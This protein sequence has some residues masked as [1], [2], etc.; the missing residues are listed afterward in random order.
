MA[1][2]LDN[3]PLRE[4][5]ADKGVPEVLLAACRALMDQPDVARVRHNLLDSCAAPVSIEP[6]SH[7]VLMMF[8]SSLAAQGIMRFLAALAASPTVRPASAAAPFTRLVVSALELYCNDEEIVEVRAS[9][10]EPVINEQPT[11]ESVP[12]GSCCRVGLL[13]AGR[14]SR[15]S[16]SQHPRR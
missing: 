10:Y 15:R 2:I 8:S 5:C 7:V 11:P 12:R 4:Q 6:H 1:N 14:N 9:L 13:D 3:D 16:L